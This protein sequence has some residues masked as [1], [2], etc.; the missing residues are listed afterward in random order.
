MAA[1]GQRMRWPGRG[2]R[3]VG[4]GGPPCRPRAAN[5]VARVRVPLPLPLPP[6]HTHPPPAQEGT[7]ERD[8]LQ[9]QVQ[10]LWLQ[11]QQ[12]QL[13]GLQADEVAERRYLEGVVDGKA[14]QGRQ[15]EAQV[16]PLL[17]CRAGRTAGI[18]DRDWGS[19]WARGIL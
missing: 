13:V 11:V 4:R 8:Q 3:G 17:G 12:L 16:G 15:L 18:S 6:R 9:V 19:G 10:D 5:C 1:L 14:L 7:L 2:C